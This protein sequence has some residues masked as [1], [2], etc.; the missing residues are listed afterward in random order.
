MK[1]NL[2]IAGFA[3]TLATTSASAVT[4]DE[5]KAAIEAA[6]QSGY[7]W[8]TTGTLMKRAEKALKENEADKA[9]K[10]LEQ[11]MLHTRMSIKQAETAKTAGPNF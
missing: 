1:L 11:I 9:Q 7:P 4:L 6:K 8:T 2:I 10:Y 3:L 5:A